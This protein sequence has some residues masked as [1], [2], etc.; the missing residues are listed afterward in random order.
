MSSETAGRV[1]PRRRKFGSR[2]LVL[3]ALATM[4]TAAG[5]LANT[6]QSVATTIPVTPTADAYVDSSQPAT[7]FG[8]STL[9]QQDSNSSS[10]MISYLTF[11]VSGLSGAPTS[12]ILHLNSE[13]TGQTPTK[14]FAVTGSWTETGVTWNSRPAIGT[15]VLGQAGPLVIGD[16]TADINGAITGNGTYSFALTNGATAVRKVDSRESAGKSPHLDLTANTTTTST[17][18]SASSSTTDSTTSTTTTPT[19]TTT[20]TPVTTST[21]STTTTPV[22][23]TSS[24]TTSSSSTSTSTSSGT[25]PVIAAGGDIACGISD[26][27]YNSGNGVTSACHMKNTANQISGLN[28]VALLPLGDEQYNSGNSTDFAASY[29]NSWGV[30]SLLN[31]SHPAVGNH[32]YGT[33]GAGGYFK[34]FGSAATGG[35]ASCSSGCGGY[36][37]YNI[38]AWHLVAINTEC[39]RIDGGTGCATGSPQEKWLK[40]DLAAHPN[41]CT[42]VY[43]HRPRWSSNSF[44]NSDIAPLIADMYPTVDIYLSGHSHAYERFKPQNPSGAVDTAK[45]ITQLI[46]GTGGSFYTGFGTILA[47]S[48]THKSNLFG[49]MKLTLHSNSADYAFLPENSTY[50]DSGTVNCH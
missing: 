15:T 41:S 1:S 42:L 34:F 44:A 25:D 22:T 10:Q 17:S 30:G 31:R 29:G 3:I 24:T 4:C 2:L 36:Y 7:N 19:T 45:G 23:T 37:S 46:V 8:T 16:V 5:L 13:V 28:P 26:P 27:N 14:V 11:T 6:A 20:T 38:G 18:S 39:T 43:G 50:T 35:G 12:A 49:V 32:E 40:A 33:S 47:N 48:V 21:T 9:L